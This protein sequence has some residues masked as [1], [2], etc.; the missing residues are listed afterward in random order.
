MCIIYYE[1]SGAVLDCHLPSLPGGPGSAVEVW[2]L[3]R[4]GGRAVLLVV[5]VEDVEVGGQACGRSCEEPFDAAVG[6]LL[7]CVTKR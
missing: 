7:L 5:H 2:V 3:G 1:K 6:R 4:S